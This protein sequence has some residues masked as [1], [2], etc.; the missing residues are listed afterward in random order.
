MCENYQL[1]ALNLFA[2]RYVKYLA[3]DLKDSSCFQNGQK[4]FTPYV[5]QTVNRYICIFIKFTTSYAPKKLLVHTNV[6]QNEEKH[7][8]LF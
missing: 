3:N 4:Y 6:Y 2:Q 5:A 7:I 1:K 8:Q